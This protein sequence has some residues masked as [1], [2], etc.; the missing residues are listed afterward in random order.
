MSSS[1]P[2]SAVSTEEQLSV[3]DALIAQP[4]PDRPGRSETWRGWGGPGYHV[5]VLRQSRD[6]WNPPGPEVFTAAEE[7]M[8]ADLG[9]LVAVLAGRWGGPTEV[10]LWPLLGLDDPD[11]QDTE[12][13]PEP[14]AS[15]C[16]V[17][18]SLQLWQVPSAGRWLGL[19]I[20]QVDREFPYELLATVADT[21]T[22]PK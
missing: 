20:G 13:P 11:C 2:R 16:M 5:A 4:F 10:D 17:A 3:I 9:A 19:T 14:L 15:L 1:R 6:F 18:G 7:E 12:E 22:L 21:S 8:E